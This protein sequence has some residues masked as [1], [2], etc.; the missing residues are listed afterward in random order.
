MDKERDGEREEERNGKL[1]GWRDR[2][3]EGERVERGSGREGEADI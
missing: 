1:D 3:R 2:E